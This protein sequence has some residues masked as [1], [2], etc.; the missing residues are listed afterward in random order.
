MHPNKRCEIL[1][2]TCNPHTEPHMNSDYAFRFYADFY[3]KHRFAEI[4]DDNY[5]D[6][7]LL[8]DFSNQPDD[9]IASKL[10]EWIEIWANTVWDGRADRYIVKSVKSH[11]VPTWG[12]P[13]Y[14]HPKCSYTSE[15]SD[16]VSIKRPHGPLIDLDDLKRFLLD[17]WNSH[18]AD[19]YKVVDLMRDI[20]TFD[21]LVPED[22]TVV[23]DKNKE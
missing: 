17:I 9:K 10:H 6:R 7:A 1:V 3:F 21:I 18:R 5:F 15:E 23:H 16:L 22:Y 2:M 11:L 8:P 4:Y 20:N 13:K 19:T 12:Y 14:H